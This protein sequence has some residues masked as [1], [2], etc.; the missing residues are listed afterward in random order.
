MGKGLPQNAGTYNTSQ[1]PSLL[2]ITVISD[3]T[4]EITVIND[5]TGAI[6]VISDCTGA[7]VEK[8]SRFSSHTAH[9]SHMPPRIAHPWRFPELGIHHVSLCNADVIVIISGY[10]CISRCFRSFPSAN[11]LKKTEWIETLEHWRWLLFRDCW[12][13]SARWS[14]DISPITFGRNSFCH[15][16]L[17]LIA[18]INDNTKLDIMKPLEILTERCWP[19]KQT[20][21]E[22]KQTHEYWIEI[23]HDGSAP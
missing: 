23:N 11:K 14:F 19:N 18:C 3:C 17:F 16:Y 12:T 4:G 13:F 6:T 7:R 9:T 5:C 10:V 15:F 21:L 1:C 20:Y 2:A 22:F 8:D